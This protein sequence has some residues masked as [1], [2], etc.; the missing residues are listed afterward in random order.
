MLQVVCDYHD[1]WIVNVLLND[2]RVYTFQTELWY[3]HGANTSWGPVLKK[4]REDALALAESGADSFCRVTG[5]QN[6]KTLRAAVNSAAEKLND[7]D[8]R[9]LIRR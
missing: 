3:E 7:A 5:Y 4:A 9:R 1:D 6:L 8:F 2:G